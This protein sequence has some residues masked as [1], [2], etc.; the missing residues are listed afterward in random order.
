MIEAP[1]H[2]IT[3][4]GPLDIIPTR[5]WEPPPEEV[6]ESAAFL[7][8]RERDPSGRTPPVELFRGWM[9]ASSPGLSALE[10]PTHDV[11]MLDCRVRPA[12]PEAEALPRAPEAGE[13]R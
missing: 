13:E 7:L 8:I 6:P 1:L 5:C 2:A 9:F 11:W 3:R 4:L 12:E 10:Y